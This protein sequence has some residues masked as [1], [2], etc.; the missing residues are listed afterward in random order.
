MPLKKVA[1]IGRVN[2]GKSTL[3]NC[4]IE[5]PKALVSSLPGTTRDRNYAHCWW[6]GEEFI[7]VD[8]AGPIK[9]KNKKQKIKNF[10][11]SLE[12]AVRRQIEL[13]IS[14]ADL[15]LF[16]LDIKA[17]ILPVDQEIARSI[18]KSGKPIILVL[19]QADNQ[20]LRK[21]ADDPDYLKFGFGQPMPVSAINGS[22][23]GDLLDEIVKKIGQF[24]KTEQIVS[25]ER[26]ELSPAKVAIIGR[27]NVGKS[28]L[29]NALLGEERVVVS[30][31]P[32]TTREPIDTLIY[33]Q[34]RPILLIDTAGIRRRAKIRNG[35][36]QIGVKKSLVAAK[37]SDLILFILEATNLVS[38][39]DK[40][41]VDLVIKSGRGLI[42]VANKIDLVENFESK[43]FKFIEYY[44]NNLPMAWW[45]PII[46]VSAKTKE[47]IKK[48]FDL[49]WAVRENQQREIE[50]EELKNF[51]E[52]VVIK[53]NFAK[54]I[55]QGV[56]LIQIEI[57]PP[58][59]L[60]KVPK[61]VLKKK[62]IH[63]A[64][65]N[66]IEKEIR[67]IWHFEGTPLII[68]TL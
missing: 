41:L 15:I 46:F 53:N 36:E 60:L 30:S 13:A 44:Q 37:R 66:I 57:K 33:H 34:D 48:I 5:Q 61:I 45:A 11:E 68:K 2:V 8:T 38:H 3:F 67:K 40:A 27:P 42:L 59:F 18:R 64:Q 62:Q 14:E 32:H 24:K 43:N 55:W 22:G 58:K 63:Q 26:L 12:V 51:I 23:T 35:I 31:V 21:L 17:G 49:I 54:S 19:N 65:L 29:L 25:S 52:S 20:K 56:K 4:L 47:N 1:L 9:T 6:R 28:S 50:S 10:T 39:Q 16:I 7:L